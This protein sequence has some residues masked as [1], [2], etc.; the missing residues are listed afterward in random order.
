MQLTTPACREQCSYVRGQAVVQ[1][2]VQLFD[3]IEKDWQTV[4]IES[5]SYHA[6]PLLTLAEI[7]TSAS[8]LLLAFDQDT[9]RM[10]TSSQSFPCGELLRD[11]GRFGTGSRCLWQTK[12]LLLLTFGVDPTLNLGD[13]ISLKEGLVR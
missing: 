6:A 10:D 2:K 5:L 9:N 1:L 7:T 11:S 12:D 4:A 3:N 13:P 8:G